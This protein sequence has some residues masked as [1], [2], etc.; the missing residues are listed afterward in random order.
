MLTPEQRILLEQLI[1][2][3]T[4][5]DVLE[6]VGEICHEKAEHVSSNWQ[7]SSLA[8]L[9]TRAG[10]RVIKAAGTVPVLT[11]SKGGK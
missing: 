10:E 2:S 11:I 3:S 9:W 4:L 8:I 5:A 7:D 6:T 1:D